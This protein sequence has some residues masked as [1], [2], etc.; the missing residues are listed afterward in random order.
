MEYWK[1]FLQLIG[2]ELSVIKSIM[3]GGNITLRNVHGF[4]SPRERG[5]QLYFQREY[6]RKKKKKIAIIDQ[7]VWLKFRKP[8]LRVRRT[9]FEFIIKNVFSRVLRKKRTN[10]YYTFLAWVRVWKRKQKWIPCS[11]YV[12]D[13]RREDLYWHGIKILQFICFIDVILSVKLPLKSLYNRVQRSSGKIN[14]RSNHSYWLH[15]SIE[16]IFCA[17]FFGFH[18]VKNVTANER[19]SFENI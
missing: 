11:W 8:V 12:D 19:A 18:N 15:D 17:S 5:R 14:Y 16:V 10:K 9:K 6:V 2:R 4:Y 13:C 1:L 3:N 7:M